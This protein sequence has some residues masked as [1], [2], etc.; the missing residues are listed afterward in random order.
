[1]TDDTI[2]ADEPDKNP[3]PETD[4]MQNDVIALIEAWQDRGIDLEKCAIL[5]TGVGHTMLI[6][7]D[8]SFGDLVMGASEQ[9]KDKDGVL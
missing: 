2:E 5:I 1:V 7:L 6:R 9:W 4:Q 3:D 8:Y